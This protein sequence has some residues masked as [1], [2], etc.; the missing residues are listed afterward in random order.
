MPL[1]EQERAAETDAKLNR[2]YDA[3][4][5][6]IADLADPMLKDRIA[7][8]NASKGQKRTDARKNGGFWRAQFCAEVPKWRARRDSNS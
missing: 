1:R 7:E 4:E 8:L 2:L 6:G 5:N 3:I